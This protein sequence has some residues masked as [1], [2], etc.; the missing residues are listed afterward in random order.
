MYLDY[1]WS[2]AR[3]LS[4]SCFLVNS[5]ISNK[6]NSLSILYLTVKDFHHRCLRVESNRCLR[7]TKPVLKISCC[8]PFIFYFA[9]TIL[10][11]QKTLFVWPTLY[12]FIKCFTCI[13]VDHK[14]FVLSRTAIV[15]IHYFDHEWRI[16]FS[17]IDMYYF[18]PRNS[19]NSIKQV[20]QLFP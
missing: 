15:S 10:M 16:L 19:L 12:V 18:E 8:T 14:Y 7:F 6:V 13:L 5:R 4:A 3:Y 20:T 1:Y 11:S 9:L 2:I 17:T